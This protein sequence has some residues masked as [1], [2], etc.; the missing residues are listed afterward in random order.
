MEA[1]LRR[2][3]A[4]RSTCAGGCRS[5]GR[6]KPLVVSLCLGHEG[7]KGTVESAP[8]T[9]LNWGANKSPHSCEAVKMHL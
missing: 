3:L 5:L 6:R 9:K 4:M 2:D 8:G 7:M 1:G